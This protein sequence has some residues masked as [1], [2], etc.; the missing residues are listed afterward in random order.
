M[1]IISLDNLP[2]GRSAVVETLGAQGGMRRRLQDMGLIRGTNVECVGVSPLGD[3][4]AYLIRDAVI[5]L[6]RKDA[7]AIGVIIREGEQED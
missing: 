1:H 6:R 4:V 5:A 3:P 2:Q 7:G